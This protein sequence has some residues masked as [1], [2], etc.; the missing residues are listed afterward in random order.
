VN[1]FT[2][3]FLEQY[4]N[5]KIHT[6]CFRARFIIKISALNTNCISRYVIGY[7]VD[8]ITRNPKANHKLK[9]QKSETLLVKFAYV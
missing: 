2:D 7:N 6:A 5:T 9:A 1:T 8:V 4:S 3:F